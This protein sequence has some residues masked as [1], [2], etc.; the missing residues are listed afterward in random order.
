MMDEDL[1]IKKEVKNREMDFG[2]K[3]PRFYT[4][5]L[6]VEVIRNHLISKGYNVSNRDVFIKG[7]DCQID[8]LVLK[9]KSRIVNP[10]LFNP[11]DVLVA[12]EI[13]KSGVFSVDSID[14]I[15]RNFD[16]ISKINPKIKCVYLTLYE[17]RK[18]KHRINK[19]KLGYDVFEIFLVV[20]KH[21][22]KPT[23][24]WNRLQN[25]LKNCRDAC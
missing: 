14:V 6:M 3:R 16:K 24:D 20:E 15:K 18:Y 9:P 5:S 10:V 25:K 4:G 21:E 13:K 19:E 11:E 17:G 23:G 22:S 1:K 2:E 7:V 12:F 8:L